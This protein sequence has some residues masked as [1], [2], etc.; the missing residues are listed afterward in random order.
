[1]KII[2]YNGTYD[3]DVEFENGVIR[4]CVTYSDFNRGALINVDYLKRIGEVKYNNYG[5]KM[6]VIDYKNSDNVYIEFDNGYKDVVMWSNFNKGSTKSPYCKSY[7][8]V[9]F[10]G[11]GEYTCDD[12]W[13]NHWRAMIER[14]TTKN[15]GLLRTYANATVYTPWYNYQIFAKWA[16]ENYYEI[17]GLKMELDKDILTKGN[18]FYSP[19]TCC[20]VPHN[21]NTLFVKSDIT[22]GDLPIGVYWHERDQE[23]RAQCSYITNTGI[24]KNKWLGGHN[25]PED[26]YLAYKK[27]K[28][29]HIKEIADRYKEYIP[30]KL[31]NAL[32]E[33]RVEI[34]D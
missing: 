33:Y 18:K 21:I 4:R 2:K 17:P 25:N 10:L 14:V 22:R 31:Y 8:G 5:S 6:T 28:E 16:K 13:H 15:D 23:Y 1:M 26:A 9:G 12:T 32:Y 7:N 30:D 27:F 34:T 19:E 3:I 20:F 29:F 24:R 11:E